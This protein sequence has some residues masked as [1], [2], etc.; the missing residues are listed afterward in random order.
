MLRRCSP[1]AALAIARGLPPLSPGD[2][3][4]RECF[5]R[6]TAAQAAQ[7][8]RKIP[9]N[10][11]NLSLPIAFRPASGGCCAVSPNHSRMQ[12]QSLDGVLLVD[13]AK[14]MTSH[15]VVAI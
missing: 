6:R 15:D 2:S 1:W 14:G 7:G 9:A 4:S 13:K 3:A 12:F 11:G 8:G 10:R 5:R